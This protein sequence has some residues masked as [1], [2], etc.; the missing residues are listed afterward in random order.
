MSNVS[1]TKKSSGYVGG[2]VRWSIGASIMNSSVNNI[3]ITTTNNS[4][5]I[6][7]GG[8]AGQIT[9]SII[10]NC[11]VK[12][13]NMNDE[14]AANS[15]IGGIVGNCASTNNIQNCYAEGKINSENR[16]VGG[17]VGNAGIINVENCYSKIDISTS[18]SN[19][20][21]ILGIYS[22][23]DISTINNNLSIGNIYTTSGMDSLNRVIGNNINTESNN[24]AYKNQLLNGY[25]REE[26]KGAILLSKEEMLN[27]NLGTSYN[28][29][30]KE[31]EI[32]P[33]LYNT[34][35]TALLPKQEDIY[36]EARTEVILEVENIEA[37]KPNTTEAEIT[38]RI[39]NPMQVEIT[40]IEIEDMKVT[41]VTRNVTQNGITSITV[42]ATPTRYYDSYKLTLIKYKMGD[43]NEQIKEVEVEIPVQFYKE[44]YTYEDWQSIEKGTYQNYRLMANIDFS[45]KTNIKNNITIN[46]LEA[47]NEIYYL[48]NINLEYNIANTGLINNVKTSMKNIGFENITLINNSSSGNYFGLIASNNG[49]M[50]NLIFKGITINSKGINYTG[51]IGGM[52][53]GNVKN[54][55][56]EDITINGNN[57]VG[58]LLR[59]CKYISCRK[60]KQYNRK[61]Y[62][63]NG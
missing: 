27:L 1:I 34:E 7:M 16:N 51:A 57:S 41:A 12:A 47:E 61:R 3:Q 5:E 49:N 36:L 48:K 33:K 2:I 11:Y 56:L 32:L 24:Y 6:Y 39:K 13:I 14:K 9:N 18:N 44:I 52:T 22:G 54:I 20:G 35:G 23:T 31:E 10:E 19:V 25:V 55:E 38:I 58:G 21:G 42:K 26:G 8:I 43:K 40:G 15:A 46:R 30:K 60:N 45:G 53:S 29:D 17:I 62:Y 63:S 4:N 28:Y 50:E 59:I 37:T